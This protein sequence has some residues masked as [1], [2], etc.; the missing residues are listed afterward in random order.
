[1][2]NFQ[3]TAIDS[4]GKRVAG[5]LAGA[6]EQA[7]LSDLESRQMMPMTIQE[8]TTRG[9][10]LRKRV[11]G[12]KLAQSYGELCDLLRAGVPLLRSLKL[13]GNRKSTPQLSQVFRELAEAVEDGEE[14]ADAMAKRPDVFSRVQIAMVRAGEKGG[15]LEDVLERLG[16]FLMNQAELRGKIVGNMT[17]PA[18]LVLFGTA[19]LMVIF[20][21]FVPMFMPI[22]D[23]LP[24]LPAV[25]KFVFGMSE[26]VTRYGVFTLT[27]LVLAGIGWWRLSKRPDVRR[28]VTEIRSSMPVIGPLVRALA[29]GRFCRMLGTMLSNGI[30]MIS[31]MQIAR[32]AAGNV[33]LEEAIDEAISAVRA[34]ESLATPLAAS[35]LFTDD[36]VEMISVA[37]SS[38]NLDN[39]LQ[40]I[41][42]TIESRIERL[43]TA[44]VKLIE[45]LLLMVLALVIVIVAAGLILPMTQMSQA[46]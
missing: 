27:A 22:F 11:G 28:K 25:T 43:L 2:P 21:K 15:F 24:Q 38:N 23:R 36:V 9:G 19:V 41:A 20:W 31:A 14:L 45:P 46:V 42:D 6:S 26:L 16:K 35:G 12:R 13:L 39:V 37:E 33:L 7:V 5:I 29:A 1:M 8:K 40:T 32:E 10:L 3:Y 4:A 34:G 30:P 17:Y 44:V 18:I